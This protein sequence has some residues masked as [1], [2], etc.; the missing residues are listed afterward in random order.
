MALQTPARV[1]DTRIGWA[2]LPAICRTPAN[3]SCTKRRQALASIAGLWY[4]TTPQ[5]VTVHL[6]AI[7]HEGELAPEATCKEF[8][9]V[10]LEG[11]RQVRRSLKHCNLPTV[12]VA[13]YH[14]RSP[15]GTQ[16]RQWATARLEEYVVKDSATDDERLK[17]R[18]G[19][20]YFD[21]LLDRIRDLRSWERVFWRKVLDIYATSGDYDPRAEARSASSR[22]CRTR[23]TGRLTDRQPPR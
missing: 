2:N 19:S 14:V 17:H 6:S 11:P 3:P 13:G 16:F 22:W 7:S 9:P 5:N 23:C 12:P 4:A 10:R 1:E 15:R 18:D 21:E 20:D 8:L